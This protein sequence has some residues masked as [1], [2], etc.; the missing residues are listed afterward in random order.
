MDL[1]ALAVFVLLGS[2][3]IGTARAAVPFESSEVAGVALYPEGR[4]PETRYQLDLEFLLFPETGWTR[5]LVLQHSAELARV[6]LQCSV[7]VSRVRIW[8]SP[9]LVLPSTLSKWEKEGPTSLVALA[10]KTIALPRPLTLLVGSFSDAEASPFS[11]ATFEGMSEPIPAALEATLWFPFYVNSPEYLDERRSSPYCS[12]AHEL[13]HILTLDGE[14]NNDPVP[15]LMTIYRRR[16][17]LLTPELCAEIVKS[18]FVRS[19]SRRP[20]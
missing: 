3:G 14:H 1:R 19:S 7:A 20:G 4:A 16:T 18:P 6:Y 13:T 10:E 15:N 5:E 17:N 8:M 12:L 11:R 2:L 9:G